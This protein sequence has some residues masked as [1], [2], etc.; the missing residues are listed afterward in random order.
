MKDKRAFWPRNLTRQHASRPLGDFTG[1]RK[2]PT[3]LGANLAASA[4]TEAEAQQAKGEATK[5]VLDYARQS[6]QGPTAG[7]KMSP[8][9]A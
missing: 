1:R 2:S 5:A 7:L 3:P 6:S 9:A 8:P 4:A